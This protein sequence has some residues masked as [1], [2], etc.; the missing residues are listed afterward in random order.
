LTGGICNSY[1]ASGFVRNPII[2]GM[3]VTII[4]LMI[5]YYSKSRNMTRL[6]VLAS[7]VNITYLFFHTYALRTYL[8]TK[9]TNSNLLSEFTGIYAAENVDEEVDFLPDSM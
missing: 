3:V 4:A 1:I 2:A 5:V 8:K 9:D 6:F 7:L